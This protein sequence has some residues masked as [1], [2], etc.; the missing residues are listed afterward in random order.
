SITAATCQPDSLKLPTPPDTTSSSAH[1]RG[2]AQATTSLSESASKNTTGTS[3]CKP[4][5]S[6]T[7]TGTTTK[8]NHDETQPCD[9]YST[10]ERPHDETLYPLRP[11]RAT[12]RRRVHLRMGRPTPGN[13]ST[14][15][16]THETIR[17]THQ[18]DRN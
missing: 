13:A 2:S 7:A 5:S 14:R 3:A 15:T 4:P 18:L 10:T 12:T 1:T 9:H 17:A 6:T 11:R 8:A 16:R